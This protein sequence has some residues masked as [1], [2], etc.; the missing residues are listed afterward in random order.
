MSLSIT[1]TLAF[2]VCTTLSLPITRSKINGKYK[3]ERRRKT[4]LN[5]PKLPNGNETTPK[6]LHIQLRNPRGVFIGAKGTGGQGTNP[7]PKR[8][9]RRGHSGA[10]HA[11]L[12]AARGPVCPLS[13]PGAGFWFCA[14]GFDESAL[15]GQ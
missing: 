15:L 5:Y 6:T 4:T 2:Q 10:A 12:R 8:R 3:G 14:P 9:A 7:G 13:G 1:S 11:V